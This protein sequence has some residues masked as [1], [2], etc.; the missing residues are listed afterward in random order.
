MVGGATAAALI[1]QCVISPLPE[2]LSE[3]EVQAAWAAAGALR[4]A[5]KPDSRPYVLF[6]LLLQTGIKKGECLGLVPNHVDLSNP[7]E[8]VLWVRY[9]DPRHRYKERKLR[10]D[11]SWIP[12][13]QAYLAQYEPRDKL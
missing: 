8:P 9:P 7:A 4:Q 11:P 6:T 5:E 13:Y 1:Q 12:A 2:L 3:R 10:L